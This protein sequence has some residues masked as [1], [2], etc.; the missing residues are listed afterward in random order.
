[1][2]RTIWIAL[3]V[4]GVV[5]KSGCVIEDPVTTTE[6]VLTNNSQHNVLLFRYINGVVTDSVLLNSGSNKI[7][8]FR[9]T[10]MIGGIPFSGDSVRLIYDDTISITHY[11]W[12]W[13]GDNV[14][15]SIALEES[16]IGGEVGDYHY[17]YEYT[18]TDAD[19][20]EALEV[21]GLK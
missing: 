16:W 5:M 9:E 20:Q 3:L 13:T 17:L 12:N 18:F 2:V 1:M 14:A 4:F 6:H 10:G 19:Y 21:N 11:S 7:Y 8:K 15:R